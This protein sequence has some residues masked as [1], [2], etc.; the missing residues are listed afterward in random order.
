MD[1]DGDG[2]GEGFGLAVW[3]QTRPQRIKTPLTAGTIRT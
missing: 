1:G 2:D 3:A